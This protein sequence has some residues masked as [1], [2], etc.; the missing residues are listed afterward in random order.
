MYRALKEDFTPSE[1]T[2]F[3]LELTLNGMGGKKEKENKRVASPESVSMHL[4]WVARVDY[5]LY[6]N[7]AYISL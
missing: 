3:L 1:F 2:P 6:F 5:V 4:M 7:F